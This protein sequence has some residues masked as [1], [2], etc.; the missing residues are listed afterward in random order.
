MTGNHAARAHSEW[1]ASASAR[2][3]G[4]PGSIALGRKVAA[5]PENRAAAWGTACHEVADWC[6]RD[7]KRAA[8][9]RIGDTIITKEHTIPVDEELAE[10]AQR[11]VDYVWSQ[12]KRAA[13]LK[14]EQKFSLAALNPP[15]EAGGTAD[16]VLYF[17]EQKTIQVVDL[18]TG[19][20]VVVEAAE[21][22][23]LRTYALGAM[24]ANPGI[25]VQWV[26]STIVQTRASHSD[27]PIRSET[28]HGAELLSWSIELMAAMHRAAA[29]I[30][31]EGQPGWA[32]RHLATGDHCKWC[33][34]AP[35]CPALQKE[36]LAKAG[37]WFSN[38]GL[39][40]APERPDDMDTERLVAILDAADMIT[41]WLN[42]VR[43]YAH[44]LANAGHKIVSPLGEYILAAKRATRQWRDEQEAE[45]TLREL[46]GDR[47]YKRTLVSP[48]QA[49][50]ALGTD[51]DPRITSLWVAESSGT[52][53]VRADK[54]R[55]KAEKPRVKD[56]FSPITD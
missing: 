51:K 26:Q 44:A 19:T 2:N 28:I 56:F 37:A 45:A 35:I 11:Y 41:E 21:N 4:C 27:G 18:K 8:L 24:L 43:A 23:Q 29:A 15:L 33:P 47:A 7:P 22:F 54:T 34:G 42:S 1:S 38:D 16:A 53:L 52:N 32:E 3:F 6:L 20:G 46:L 5:K 36:A 31:E 13:W 48:A 14:V 10:T 30:A 39:I 40:K 17:P 12:A 55:R 25:D 50:K 49:E 9:Q